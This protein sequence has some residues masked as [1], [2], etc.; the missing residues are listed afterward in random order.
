MIIIINTVHRISIRKFWLFS[1]MSEDI[2]FMEKL[3]NKKI[4]RYKEN[5]VDNFLQTGGRLDARMK[6]KP[7]GGVTC[8]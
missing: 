4:I 7:G 1:S 3:S 6:R 5:S 2:R 8:L